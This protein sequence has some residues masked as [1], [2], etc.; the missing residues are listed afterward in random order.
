MNTIQVLV[1]GKELISVP[2]GT[3]AETILHQS[4]LSSQWGT[5]ALPFAPVAVLVQH[6]LAALSASIYANCE[7][8]PVYPDTPLGAEVYRHS[9]CFLLAMAARTIVPERR[10]TV[11]MAINNGYYHYFDDEDPVSNE[12]LTVLAKKMRSYV[13]QDLTIQIVQ[14]TWDEAFAYFKE[15]NQTDTLDLMEY[16]N[17]PFVAMNECNGYRDLYVSP[18][19][20]HTGLLR[21]WELMPYRRGMLLRFPHTKRPYEMDKFS[22]VPVL[23][24][25]AEE[26]EKKQRCSMPPLSARSIESINLV[27]CKISCLWQKHCRTKN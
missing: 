20:S 10:L 8:S 9:L 18:L 13:A 15:T 12:L 21:I 1:D 2:V 5:A 16:S 7:L 22:D 26:Y 6:E 4:S 23:Y 27:V 17:E 14:H 24:T 19:V 3:D 11:S 25:I